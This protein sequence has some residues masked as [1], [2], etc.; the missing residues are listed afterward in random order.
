R[1][2]EVDFNNIPFGRIFS[3]HMFM[4]DYVDGQWINAEIKPVEKML[5]HPALMALHYGQSIFEGLKASKTKDGTAVFFRPD[6]HARRFI[7]SAER[8]C[9]PV[10]PEEMFIE[11][12][13]KLV[14]IDKE[15]IPTQRGSSLY[16]RPLMFATDE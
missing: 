5:M 11:A 9:M 7:A 15:W 4:A 8:M 16:V 14:A 1:L 13:M 10:L 3:D 2:S 12:I 6:A